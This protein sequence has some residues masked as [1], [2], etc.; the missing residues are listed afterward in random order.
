MNNRQPVKAQW[1]EHAIPDQTGR[2]IIVTGANSGLGWETARALAQKGATVIMAC[3]NPPKAEAAA[4]RIAALGPAGRTVVMGLDLADLDSVRSFAAAFRRIHNR[5]DGLVNNAGVGNFPFGRTAQGFELHFG[6]NHLAHFAL[7]GLL[8]DLLNAASGARV[9]TV[10]SFMHRFGI[11]D[12]ADLNW[13]RRYPAQGPYA[14][15]KLEN[16]LFTYELQ[17]RLTAAGRTTIAAAAH[18]GWSST[19]LSSGTQFPGLTRTFAQSAARGALPI[20][21]AATA[22]EIRGGDFT[23]PDGFMGLRGFPRQVRS[24]KRSH[25]E[26]VARRL[27]TVSEE[28]TGVRYGLDAERR[29]EHPAG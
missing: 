26:A 14:A 25:D 13:E 3:R 8:L 9:V 22:L 24:A 16:L 1:T 2:V 27:W 19:P 7:T 18:P 4:A 15:S 10:S 20:L 23:G 11:V 12:F 5:L 28:V 17:R 21:Y 29:E 6:V